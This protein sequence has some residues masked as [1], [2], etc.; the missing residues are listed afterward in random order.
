MAEKFSPMS[1]WALGFALF[2]S[3]NIHSHEV[4]MDKV[5]RLV[6]M[7]QWKD[8]Q[9]QGYLPPFSLD[10][11]SGFIHLS[12]W[13]TV[14]TTANLYFSNQVFMVAIEIK[15]SSLGDKLVFEKVPSR[16]NLI[17]PHFYGENIPAR[18]FERVA[19]LKQVDSSGFTLHSSLPY[20]G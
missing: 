10:I 4:T 13:E 7:A 17:F 20:S 5:Y 11:Q 2:S 8:I 12:L 9:S 19:I 15:A 14:L 16:G 6:T 18:F 3:G 1:S